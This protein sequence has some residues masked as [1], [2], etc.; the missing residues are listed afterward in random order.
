MYNPLIAGG[1]AGALLARNS[2]VAAMVGG[3]AAFAAF[4]GAI[5]L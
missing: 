3:G 4:S 2:G 1:M 5:E